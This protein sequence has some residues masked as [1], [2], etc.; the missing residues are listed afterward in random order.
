[1]DPSTMDRSAAAPAV[2]I[3][4]DHV[5]VAIAV[6]NQARL[7]LRALVALADCG[8]DFHTVVIDDAS[9]DATEAIVA[10]VS[11]DFT[12][13]RQPRP[14]GLAAGYDAGVAAGEQEL[15]VFLRADLVPTAGWL[16]HLLEP[17]ADLSV[18]AVRPRVLDVA[19]RDVTGSSW[20]CLAVRRAA[21]VEVGGL[22][23]PSRPGRCVKSTFTDA[24]RATG[25]QLTT[26]PRSL[27]LFVPEAASDG[28]GVLEV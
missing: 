5:T 18:A 8:D 16:A 15:V 13:V 27:L 26:A 24:L 6:H 7:L 3:S 12:A 21:F 11:G 25:A 19:G 10:S 9:T 20:P 23:G 14:C 22:S 1:M 2:S 4:A 17:F 28:A